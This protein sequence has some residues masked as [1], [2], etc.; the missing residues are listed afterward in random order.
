MTDKRQAKMEYKM[1]QRPIGIFQIRNVVNGKVFVGSSVNLDAMFNRIRFQLYAG[2]HMNKTL[3]SDWRLYGT[4][5]FEFE[6]LEKI[7][8]NLGADHDYT[9]DLEALEDFWLDKLQPYD[10]RGYN[11]RKK[12]REERLRMIASNRNI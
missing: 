11:V 4:G 5:K 12:T 8:Q 7:E 2:A 9:K 10:D 6:V 3:V 1:S